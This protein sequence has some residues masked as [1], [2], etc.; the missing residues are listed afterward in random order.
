MSSIAQAQLHVTWH[1]RQLRLAVSQYPSPPNVC[2]ELVTP[3]GER[4][5]TAT[6]PLHQPLP[7]DM[8]ALKTWTE[9]EGIQQALMDA[10]VIERQP[11]GWVDS[12]YVRVWIFPLTEA[13][14]QFQGAYL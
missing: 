9:N 14:L 11:W 6:A 5:A 3:D 8:V 4:Y 7:P 12:G 1:G 13:F 2:L 10:N